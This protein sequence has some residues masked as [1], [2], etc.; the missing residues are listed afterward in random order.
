[1]T[2]YCIFLQIVY[3]TQLQ[4]SEIFRLSCRDLVHPFLLLYEFNCIDR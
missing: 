4:V 2:L 3:F 1:M